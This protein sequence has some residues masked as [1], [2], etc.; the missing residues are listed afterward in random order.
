MSIDYSVAK[1]ISRFTRDRREYMSNYFRRKGIKIGENCNVISN[2]ET[3]E[4][5]LIEI[6]SN[7]TISSEVL[8]ITHDA[9]VGKIFGK[10]VASDLVGK[11]KIGNNCFIGARST[12]LYGV[13]L[14]DNVIVAAGSVVTK[15]FS[16]ENI[17][18]GGNPAKAISTWEKFSKDKMDKLYSIHG[19]KSYDKKK[20]IDG[21]REKLIER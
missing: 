1:F 2:I 8:F 20:I 12:I 18:I 15:S 13:T 16:E 10:K 7:T 3:S 11:I 19:K 6:G 17:I 21:N 5:Y 9:S 14:A 4:S